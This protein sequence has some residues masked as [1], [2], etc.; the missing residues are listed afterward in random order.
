M[1]KDGAGN[2]EFTHSNPE[3]MKQSRHGGDKNYGKQEEVKNIRN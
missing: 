2:D 1:G 3:D